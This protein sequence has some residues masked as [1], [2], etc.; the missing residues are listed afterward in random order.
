M[1]YLIKVFYKLKYLFNFRSSLST[2]RHTKLSVL[3]QIKKRSQRR[4]SRRRRRGGTAQ[5]SRFRNAK[6]ASSK[7]KHLSSRPLLETL[8]RFYLLFVLCADRFYTSTRVLAIVYI[9]PMYFLFVTW[10]HQYES[11]KILCVDLSNFFVVYKS[12]I[13]LKYDNCFY[14]PKPFFFLV[15]F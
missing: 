11:N 13:P 7:R 9:I 12:P 6:T 1:K 2:K 10:V 4:K 8:K 14:N 3:T 5:N 15:F